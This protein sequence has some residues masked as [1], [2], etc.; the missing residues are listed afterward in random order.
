M[1]PVV[2]AVRKGHRA[3]RREPREACL[4]G[5]LSQQAGGHFLSP[6][7]PQKCHDLPSSVWN[8]NYSVSVSVPCLHLNIQLIQPFPRTSTE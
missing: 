1:V 4:E 5:A 7:P 2:R 8:L 6:S 3:Q